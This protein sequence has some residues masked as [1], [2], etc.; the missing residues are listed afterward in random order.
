[1]SL[2]IEKQ[3]FKE[4]WKTPIIRENFGTIERT[5]RPPEDE[6]VDNRPSDKIREPEYVGWNIDASLCSS[7]GEILLST[8]D[9]P[10]KSLETSK[11]KIILKTGAYTLSDCPDQTRLRIQRMQISKVMK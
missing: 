6:R 7:N 5:K 11:E 10:P 8:S 3:S 1:M 2:A 9:P 4:L